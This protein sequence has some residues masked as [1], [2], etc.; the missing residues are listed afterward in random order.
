MR[1]S[2]ALLLVIAAPLVQAQDVGSATV[3]P[4]QVTG[5]DASRFTMVVLGDGYTAAEQAKFRAHLDRHLNI[6]W[7]IEPFRSYRNYFNVYAVS[8][9]SGESGIHCDPEVRER[10]TTPLMLQFGGGCTNINARGVTVRQG[11]QPVVQEYA[12]RATPAPDQI[13]I[14][15][16]SDTYGG[17]GGRIA[18]TTGGNAISPL[19]TPHELGHSLGGLTDE[20][21]YSARGRAGDIYDRADEPAA[22]HMTLLTEDQMRTRPLKWWRWLGEPSESG[23]RIGRYE[24]GMGNTRGVWRPSKHSMMISL[25]YYFDQVS[26]ERMTERIAERTGMIAAATSTDAPVGR[27][28]TLWVTTAHPVYHRLDIAWTTGGRGVPTARNRPYLDL[29]SLELAAGEQVVTVTVIDD[30]P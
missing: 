26:L 30:T 24:G 1:W 27:R 17:I 9:V 7:S 13:L 6:L 20:Y 12:Q 18:T 23:G 4:I 3:I 19:I 14:I 25:G 10:R 5:D 2:L 29:S 15:A 11:G 21:T 8:I 22:I 16:N 28:D